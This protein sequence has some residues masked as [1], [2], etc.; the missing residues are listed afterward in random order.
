MHIEKLSLTQFKNHHKSSFDFAKDINCFYGVN[1]AGKT[2]ILDA[3]HYVAT[4]KSYFGRMDGNS[5]QFD[6][7]FTLVKASLVSNHEPLEIQI[8]LSNPG[9]KAIRKNGVLIKRLADFIGLIPAVMITPGD[10]YL[11][12]GHSDD[13]RKFIDKTLGYADNQYLKQVIQH[14]KLLET[15][16]ELLKQFFI[17]QKQDLIALESIDVQL[18]PLVDFIAKKRSDFVKSVEPQLKEI[19]QYLV[20]SAEE[21]SISYESH[22]N[23]RRSEEL[24]KSSIPNDLASQRTSMGV[25]KDDLSVLI[26]NVSVKK[27]GSQGQIKSATIALN[28][29]AYHHIRNSLEI[30]PLLLLDDIFEKIDDVRSKRLLELI[31][32]S[33]FGQIFITDT[34]EKRL[35]SKLKELAS[36]KKF[37]NIER[38]KNSVSQ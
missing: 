28:L 8:G 15:R 19:Y 34:S 27:Y 35:K 20:H 16:N 5:I 4:G 38:P 33:D 14:N 25:H 29:A 32:S 11:L 1:G 7:D 21:I 2:N 37:F 23:D 17:R 31:S 36:D 22:L 13:R 24:L 18:A 12:T 26:N 3:L 9:K 6:T 10:I 30:T